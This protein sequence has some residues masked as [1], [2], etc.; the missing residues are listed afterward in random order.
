[1]WKTYPADP[2]GDRDEI[3]KWSFEGAPLCDGAH[4]YVA[5]R[6]SGVPP[7]AHVACLDAQTGERRWRR[8]ICE[9]HTLVPAEADEITHHL[10]TLA[11]DTIYYNTN[12]GA[13]AA[14]RA[15]DG[16][17]RWI[18][19]YER[20]EQTSPSESAGHMQRDLTPCIYHQGLIIAAPQDSQ[21]VLGLDAA[22]GQK[23]WDSNLLT[24]VVHLLGVSGDTLVASGRSLWWV[25][26]RSGKV[27]HCWPDVQK[28]GGGGY[29]RGL[30]AAGTVYWP[31]RADANA[32]DSL[33][34]FEI[35]RAEQV[36]EPID[37]RVYGATAGNLVM[38]DDYL[39]IAGADKLFALTQLP[40]PRPA[41]DPGL[42]QTTTPSAKLAKQ[43]QE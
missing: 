13:I 6:K 41:D 21:Y 25:N 10:L 7:Q 1:M 38:V 11:E 26:I 33:Y 4:V 18:R 35:R 8:K 28:P 22:T 14:L 15:S 31:V 17:I 23:L 37:L 39:V 20:V 40:R 34:V 19:Q 12:L 5:V 43:E 24:D 2:L 9:A 36:Q 3:D 32:S 27:L 30:L 16:Q 42:T 29:G